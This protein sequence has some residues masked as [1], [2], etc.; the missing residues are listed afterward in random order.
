MPNTA[1]AFTAF[2]IHASM[3]RRLGLPYSSM[4]AGIVLFA[5]M[6][7]EQGQSAFIK[8]FHLALGHSEDRVSEWIQELVADGWLTLRRHG[9]D[10]RRREVIPSERLITVF[11]ECCRQYNSA[12]ATLLAANQ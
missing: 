11:E 12:E 2:S 5:L 10:G 4:A 1:L 7:S 3:S 8:D 6:R 9:V